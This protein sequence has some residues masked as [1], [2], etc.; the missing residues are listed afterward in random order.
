LSPA[1]LRDR[2]NRKRRWLL[3]RQLRGGRRAARAL[4]QAVDAWQRFVD[5]T[6]A[7]VPAPLVDAVERVLALARA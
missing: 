2:R 4:A 7:D 5:A 1:G 6:A 3:R